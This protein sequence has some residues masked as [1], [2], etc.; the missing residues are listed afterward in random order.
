MH[1]EVLEGLIVVKR[2]GQR[3][4]FNAS[5]IAIAIKKAF[6]SV[7]EEANEKQIYKVFESVLKYI[8]EN[9]KERKTINVEDIQ[10]IIEN[11]LKE[12]KYLDVYTS[13]NDY[14]QKRTAS[15]KVFAEKQQHKFVKAIEKI[16]EENNLKTDTYLTPYNTLY[17]FGK[18]VSCEYTKSYLLDSKSVKASEEGNIFIHDLDYFALGILSSIHLK[19]KSYTDDDVLD[20]LISEIINSQK[21]INGEIEIDGIDY[22]LSPWIINEYQRIFKTYLNHYLNVIGL[23]DY[24]NIKKIEEI[25]NKDGLEFNIDHYSQFILN[26]NIKNIFNIAYKDTISD[27]NNLIRTVLLKLFKSLI[28]NIQRNTIFSIST[29]TNNSL[30]GVKINENLMDILEDQNFNKISVIFKIKYNINEE[31]LNRI[32]NLILNNKNIYLAFIDNSY[33]KNINEVEYFSNGMRIFENINSNEEKSSGRMIVS[34]TSI[35]LARLGLKYQNKPLKDFYLELDNIFDI[36]KNELLLSFETIGNKNRDNYE[37]LFKGNVYDDEK[38]EGNQHI[39]KVIKNGT[40]NIGLIGLK[41]CAFILT[42]DEE[43]AYKLILDI[44]KELNDKCQKLREETKLNFGLFEPNDY[45]SRKALIGIDKAIYG[46]INNITNKDYYELLDSFK[47][48]KDDYEKLGN[49][50]KL[51]TNGMLITINLSSNPSIKKINNIIKE[52]IKHNLGFIRIRS[53]KNE[54]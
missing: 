6:D 24:L 48:F 21:E 9:Y 26:D 12:E 32:S 30:I 41:E 13:F 14:R 51:L 11:K 37:V 42:K 15:R 18:I 46:V 10:D 47:I 39:R 49:I 52:A 45:K 50:Q 5:K 44:L 29:G 4:D 53:N 43:K 19:L 2:S 54:N 28:N 8:N 38:L 36:V 35:N 40:L 20:K 27:I 33:N 16:Q 1:N 17:K 22:L 25:I 23:L 34:S 7:S 31:Y 3:V